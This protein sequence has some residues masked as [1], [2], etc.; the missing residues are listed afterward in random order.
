ME[1]PFRVNLNSEI[2]NFVGWSASNTRRRIINAAILSSS[3]VKHVRGRDRFGRS[4][5]NR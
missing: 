1:P 5:A 2:P 4:D 3:G